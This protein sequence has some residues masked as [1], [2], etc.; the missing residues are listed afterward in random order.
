[1][2]N[3]HVILISENERGESTGFIGGVFTQHVF[4]PEIR[5]L[6]ESFW[7]VA[8]E[9]RGTR[10]GLLLLN[11]FVAFG[12]ANAH[13]VSVGIEEKSPIHERCLTKRGF[14]VLEKNY[15]LEVS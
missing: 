2:I 14:K 1:M 13:W 12:K 15:L 6:S 8:P 3:S 5:V 10:A 4:N 11:E 7:W 9:Y